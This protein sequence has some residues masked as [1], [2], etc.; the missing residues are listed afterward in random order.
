MYS[1]IVSLSARP[2]SLTEGSV[3]GH[4]HMDIC[5]MAASQVVPPAEPK[6]YNCRARREQSIDT[7]LA[8]NQRVLRGVLRGCTVVGS[9]GRSGG[10]VGRFW[11][12]GSGG[13]VRTPPLG[14]QYQDCSGWDLGHERAGLA[15]Y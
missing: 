11:D 6:A 12:M 1:A 13:L 5:G 8:K 10:G 7:D 15:R 9:V 2:G 14:V 4:G 3:V